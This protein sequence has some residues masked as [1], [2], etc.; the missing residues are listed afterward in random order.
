MDSDLK[1]KIQI[2]LAIGIV[3]VGARTAWIMYERSHPDEGT[4]REAAN[5]EHHEL[6]ADDYVYERPFYGYDLDSTKKAL[7]GKTTWMKAGYY[8]HA[9]P[10]D[11]ATKRVTRN[12]NAP[13]IPP[14][15]PIAITDIVLAPASSGRELFAIYKRGG[16]PVAV[17]LGAEQNGQY[18]MDVENVLYRQDPRELFKHWSKDTWAAI[19]RHEAI[20]GMNEKQVWLALGYRQPL[21]SGNTGDRTMHYE[22]AGHPKDVRFRKNAA[23]E[24]KDAE[25]L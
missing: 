7:V 13:L 19:E 8:L 16:K 20:A 15:E 1:R 17:H 2:I 22:N 23:V 21:S 9:Y 14:L 6:A 18:R 12:D 24:I 4:A 11:P 5:V 25:R 3:L 10:Y